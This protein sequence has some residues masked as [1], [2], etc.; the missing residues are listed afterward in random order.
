[1]NR[2]VLQKF[3]VRNVVT[4]LFVQNFTNGSERLNIFLFKRFVNQLEGI[5]EVKIV[6]RGIEVKL[7]KISGAKAAHTFEEFSL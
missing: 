3:E 4:G 7:N 6:N 2:M 1:M 5:S